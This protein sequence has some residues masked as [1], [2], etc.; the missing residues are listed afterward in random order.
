MRAIRNYWLA[1]QGL[2]LLNLSVALSY[3]KPPECST[4][5]CEPAHGRIMAAFYAAIYLIALGAGGVKPNIQTLGGDQFDDSVLEEKK[6]RPNF[7]NLL[8][9]ALQMGS[10]L[11][12]SV[13]VYIQVRTLTC[14]NSSK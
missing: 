2:L 13:I 5:P 4:L 10:L 9:F 7:F 14:E 1:R 11:V 12:L 3:F 6:Q 8:A